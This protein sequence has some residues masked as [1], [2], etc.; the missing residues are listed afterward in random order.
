[1]PRGGTLFDPASKKPYRISRSGLELFHDCP[2][3]FYYDKRPGLSRP[4]GFPFNLN[5]AVDVLLKR[6]FDAYRYK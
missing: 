4:A 3:F 1:M 6:E 5:A 2:R